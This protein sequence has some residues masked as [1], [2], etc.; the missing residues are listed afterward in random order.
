MPGADRRIG[1]TPIDNAILF[2]LLAAGIVVLTP[3]AA[4]LGVPEPVLLTVFGLA[5]GAVPA[6]PPLHIDPDLI[7]PIVLPPLL[8][9]ATQRSTVRDFRDKAGAVVLLAVGLTAA[10]TAAVAVVAHAAGFTWPVAWVLGAVLA[11]P[12]PRRGHLCRP[13]AAAAQRVGHG[14]RGRR[15]LQR[16]DRAR[17]VQGCGG[18]DGHRT[19]VG[20]GRRA[21]PG[22]VGGGRRRR[23]P[24]AGVGVP[25]RSRRPG[26]RARR[27]HGDRWRPL[28]RVSG[29]RSAARVGRAGRAGAGV[30]TC[31]RPGAPR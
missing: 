24:R 20:G 14:H 28:R 30:S 18:R 19:R 22:A 2:G 12:D 11:A 17:V 7:L 3:A 31:V 27:D 8:F 10:T 25:A 16:R 9:A 13:S 15:H 1:C 21:G 23:R 29:R 6:V 26:R 4:R 5:L